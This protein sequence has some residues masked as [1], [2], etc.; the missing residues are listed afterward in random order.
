MGTKTTFL[1]FQI[2]KLPW[3]SGKANAC[4]GDV[5]PAV[6]TTAL[7]NEAGKLTREG[8]KPPSF[9][10]WGDVTLTSRDNSDDDAHTSV[11]SPCTRSNYGGKSHS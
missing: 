10:T 6:A 11:S 3:D 7:S 5:R 2:K 9:Q 4:G 1:L 8:E